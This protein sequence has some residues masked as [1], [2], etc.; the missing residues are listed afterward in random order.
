LA[1]GT[2]LPAS[3]FLALAAGPTGVYLRL[4]GW[5]TWRMAADAPGLLGLAIMV[6]V[7]TI[8]L[9]QMSFARPRLFDA[10]R[11]AAQLTALCGAA[12]V[13]VVAIATSADAPAALAATFAWL[14][15]PLGVWLAAAGLVLL[16]ERGQHGEAVVAAV[17]LIT[18]AVLLVN[19]VVA[20]SL[21]PLYAARRIV[22]VGLPLAAC[23]I[24][25][26][27]TQPLRTSERVAGQPAGAR[28]RAGARAPG[29]SGS[30]GSGTGTRDPWPR[31]PQLVGWRGS[32]L[33]AGAALALT[34]AYQSTHAATLTEFR[35]FAGTS[36]LSRAIARYAG[37]GALMVFPSTLGG[38]NAGRL[39]APVWAVHGVETAVLARPDLEPSRVA[40]LVDWWATQG[41]TVYFVGDALGPVPDLPGYDVERLGEEGAVSPGLAPDP[42]LPPRPTDF[43]LAVTVYTFVRDNA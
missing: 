10:C 33:L 38:S 29:A 5:G 7:T 6:G 27:I 2:A 28:A 34:L 37:P 35:D 1:F 12:I 40:R 31:G 24:A 20:Q 21:S 41:R 39:A 22:P 8:A 23:L 18:F 13:S 16:L 25:F 43:D 17:A 32:A 36:T 14:V 26:A 9:W 19:P 42:H 15:G 30:V 11:R 4:N 3:H